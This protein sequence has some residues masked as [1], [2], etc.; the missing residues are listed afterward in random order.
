MAAFRRVQSCTTLTL[1]PHP[2]QTRRIVCALL[3]PPPLLYSRRRLSIRPRYPRGANLDTS[4]GTA[5]EPYNG[6]LTDNLW[7]PAPQLDHDFLRSLSNF[8]LHL[9]RCQ[10]IHWSL[11]C[12]YIYDTI[13]PL[14][15]LKTL[16]AQSVSKTSCLCL[17]L[18]LYMV[19]GALHYYPPP[20]TGW[21]INPIGKFTFFNLNTS[22]WFKS[23]S[24]LIC[25]NGL[26]VK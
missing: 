23:T 17:Y 8:Q 26:V 5:A 9:I 21:Y 22:K 11:F 10:Y 16:T 15:L 20:G 25:G 12:I 19:R 4:R 24:E 7:L 6:Q 18:F 14:D 2:T 1:S 13:H 3:P